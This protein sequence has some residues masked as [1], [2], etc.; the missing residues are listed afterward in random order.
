MDAAH[1]QTRTQ[2]RRRRADACPCA[3]RCGGSHGRRRNAHALG[4]GCERAPARL[5]RLAPSHVRRPLSGYVQPR[6]SPQPIRCGRRRRR[7]RWTHPPTPPAPPARHQPVRHLSFHVTVCLSVFAAFC[8]VCAAP[9]LS[10]QSVSSQPCTLCALFCL[11]PSVLCSLRYAGGVLC[12]CACVGPEFVF[13]YICSTACPFPCRTTRPAGYY[14][15][16]RPMILW[17]LPCTCICMSAFP[18]LCY[19]LDI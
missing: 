13:F 1:R 16:A 3:G 12:V 4:C 2:R 17:S 18:F 6:I 8:P 10:G 5:R 11:L 9:T 14:P 19:G 7:L 15:T